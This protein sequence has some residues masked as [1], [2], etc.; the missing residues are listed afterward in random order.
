MKCIKWP[1]ML[2][3]LPLLA[4]A[5][6]AGI[7]SKL[8]ESEFI[9]VL[10]ECIDTINIAMAYQREVEIKGTSN[11]Q[12]KNELFSKMVGVMNV[13]EV[14][15]IFIKDE[16]YKTKYMEALVSGDLR[17]LK[18]HLFYI[19]TYFVSSLEYDIVRNVNGVDQ[20]HTPS[21]KIE[22]DLLL[23]TNE[24]AGIEQRIRDWMKS[25]LQADRVIGV[26]LARVDGSVAGLCVIDRLQTSRHKLDRTI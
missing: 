9:E 17:E 5:Y 11:Y 7:G 10:N 13:L 26:W 16:N 6:N 8:D 23:D 24:M 1:C 20:I 3:S 22:E 19:Y 15:S 4:R 14:L 18:S 21:F 2:L 25:E 12:R